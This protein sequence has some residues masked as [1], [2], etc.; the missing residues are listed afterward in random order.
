[1]RTYQPKIICEHCGVDFTNR[2]YAERISH[3]NA[4]SDWNM[5]VF[6]VRF[7]KSRKFEDKLSEMKDSC[8]IDERIGYITSIETARC[9]IR[10]YREGIYTDKGIKKFPDVAQF[11]EDNLGMIK[12]WYNQL[13]QSKI[14]EIEKESKRK[15]ENYRSQILV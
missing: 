12:V 10:R 5:E 13:Y 4:T 3:Q 9:L 14:D 6:T 8:D 7:K 1:M 15:I 11:I 2:D